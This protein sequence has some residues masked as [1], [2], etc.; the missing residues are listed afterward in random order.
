M[1]NFVHFVSRIYIRDVDLV[2]LIVLTWDTQH[3][4]NV[5]LKSQEVF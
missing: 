5:S 3:L 1:Y 2:V 4:D